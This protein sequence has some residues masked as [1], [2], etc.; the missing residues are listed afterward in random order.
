MTIFLETK[1]LI[2]KAPE[3]SDFPDLIKLRSDADVMRYIGKNGATQ[4]Q[5]EIA[6]FLESAIAY[7]AK[8]GF[9]F[10]SV[11]EKKSENFVGQAGLCHLGFDENQTEIE[12]AYRLH[13]DYWGKGYATELVRALIEW[14]FEH[15][16]VKK[17]IAAIHP[18][19]IASKRVLEKVDMLYIGKKHYRNIEV[20]YYE[21]YKNDSIQLVP[22]DPT[23]MKMAKSEIRILR[24][25][26]PQ[27][28]VLDIQH[29]GSTAIP[30]IQAKPIIDIQIAVD[31]LVTIKPI[32]IELLEKHGYVYWHDN[33]DLE[34]MFFVKGMPPFGE[35]RTHHVHI[36]EPSS[37]HWEGKLYFRDYLRL[38]PDVAKEYEGLK[39]SLQKQYTY[40]RERYTK[41]KTEFINA[42][43]KKA[44]LEFYP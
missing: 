31:S 40:D 24:E 33:P 23:W 13:K 37:Q 38:H 12:I 43:L 42:I 34:R 44:R 6:Q 10:C 29:V 25:L 21:I 32:A 3:L 7:Q 16:P 27:N 14:G 15:L 30:N 20:D 11:F 41:A 36:V 35:K 28:H 18:E 22:Y 1:H 39:I 26:L 8:H 17:L 19:N 5:Q 9:G 4:T 2:L